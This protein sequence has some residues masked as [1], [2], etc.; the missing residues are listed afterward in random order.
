M[1]SLS[2]GSVL[3]VGGCGVSIV[4]S[5]SGVSTSSLGSIQGRVHG[6][7]QAVVGAHVYLYAVGTTGNAGKDIAPSTGNASV[8]LLTSS[9]EN[10]Q[11]DGTNYFVT[12]DTGG[13]FSITGDYTC[14]SGTQVYLYVVGGDP[15]SGTNSRA[16]F[17]SGVGECPSGASTLD[18]NAFFFVNEVTTVATAYALAGY[19]SDALHI[20]ANTGASGNPAA[21]LEATGVANAMAN[22][23]NLVN[24]STGAALSTTP[25]GNGSVPQ[26][27]INT[28]GNILAACI[29]ASD[30]QPGNCTTLFDAALSDGTSGSTPGD[31]ATAAINIA[32]NAGQNAGTLYGLQ[33][34]LAAPFIPDLGTQPNDFGIAISFAGGGAANPRSVAIDAGGNVWGI[35]AGDVV[36][37]YSPQGVPLAANGLPTATT[38]DLSSLVLDTNGNAWAMDVSGT[39]TEFSPSGSTLSASGGVT[40][41]D[42]GS[43]ALTSD[44][45][46][47]LWSADATDASLSRFDPANNLVVGKYTV[48]YA[49]L[50]VADSAGYLWLPAD[51]SLYKVNQTGAIVATYPSLYTTTAAVAVDSTD[52]A[53][54][55]DL[56]TQLIKRVGSDGTQTSF[57]DGVGGAQ[58][59]AVDGM[60]DIWSASS[61]IAEHSS[62]GASLS[63]AGFLL[64]AGT[65]THSIAIDSSGDLWAAASTENNGQA[66]THYIEYIGM[67][68]PA[69]TPLSYAATHGT[70]QNAQN[71]TIGFNG[72]DLQF[73]YMDQI[74][75]ATNSYYQSIGQSYPTGARYCHAYLSWDIAQQA[76]GFGPE[77][78]EGSRA[79]FEDWLAHAQGHCDRALVTFKYI[80][81]ITQTGTTYP[82]VADYETAVAAFLNT[83]WSYTG[84][85]GAIDYTPWNEP[86]NG[87]G[88]GDGLTVSIPAETDADYYLALRKHCIPS[89]CTVA[90][91]DFGSNGN[92]W[93]DFVQNCPDDSAALCSGASYMDQY[94]H[95]IVT[96]APN[97][98]FTSAFRPEVFAYHGWDDVNNYINSGSHCTDPQRCTIRALNTALTDGSWSNSII[99]DTEVAAGQYSGTNPTPVVQACAV[100]YLFD[101]TASVSSRITRIYYTQP[102]TTGGNYFSIFNSDGTPKPAFTVVADHSISYTPTDGSTCP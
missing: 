21:Q 13:N 47:Y 51:K 31:V 40:G 62:S 85:T 63:G 19:A 59:I 57:G 61:Q 101:L 87:S 1:V 88:S 12:T 35:S 26:A 81:G 84:W 15:G 20:S 45:F 3:F 72:P 56:T 2:L 65:V 48:A 24:I 95:W 39:Y 70:L 18:P 78:T 43:S 50:V 102:Y 80:N 36:N 46:G 90:G 66:G 54:V 92:M 60:N 30:A 44:S 94:K 25:G 68:A 89:S 71:L 7:Q 37:L 29:N 5:S 98:G 23:N 17:L 10:V 14:T 64:P 4:P 9:G 67:A 97:Y 99:W 86:Q 75:A 79:W 69:M 8:S 34:G 28:L 74:Y 33:S 6:G 11:S 27:E 53:Y 55:D 38:N 41:G 32:H 16:A 96:D 22:V 52:A 73:P 100:A 49:S 83:S 93:Q 76:V 58:T 82:A 77:G 42:S 91:G